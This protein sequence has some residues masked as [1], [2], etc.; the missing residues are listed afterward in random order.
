MSINRIASGIAVISFGVGLI[1]PVIF[2]FISALLLI[3]G[4][5][6]VIVGIIILLNKK[7]DSIEQINERRKKWT[8]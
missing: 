7:E 2:G 8:I 1:I 3:Y 4:I 5:P 6:L